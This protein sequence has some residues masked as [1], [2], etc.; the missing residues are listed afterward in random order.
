MEVLYA[1]RV[2]DSFSDYGLEMLK[3][4]TIFCRDKMFSTYA[5]GRGDAIIAVVDRILAGGDKEQE[6][7]PELDLS[8]CYIA[9]EESAIE[10]YPEEA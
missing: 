9:P 7:D 5:E 8:R 6:G 10:E 3:V 4:L 2:E 1:S